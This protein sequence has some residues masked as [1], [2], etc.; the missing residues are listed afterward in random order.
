M[1]VRCVKA[2]VEE[3]SILGGRWGVPRNCLMTSVKGRGSTPGTGLCAELSALGEIHF[4]CGYNLRVRV[5]GI[6]GER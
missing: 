4:G 3:S 6:K 5:A 2:T 1:Q